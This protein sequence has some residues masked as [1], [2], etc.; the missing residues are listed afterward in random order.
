MEQAA[1]Q[2]IGGTLP[3]AMCANAVTDRSV[4]D[5]ITAT[6]IT[7]KVILVNAATGKPIGDV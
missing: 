2:H 1:I 5:A 7:L 3:K 6:S 4:G